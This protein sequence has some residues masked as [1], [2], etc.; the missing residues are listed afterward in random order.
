MNRRFRFFL[1]LAFASCP[2]VVAQ[3]VTTQRTSEHAGFSGKKTTWN[4]FDRYDFACAGRPCLVVTPRRVAPGTPWIW[5]A[6]FFGHRPEVDIALLSKGFHLAFVD[7]IGMFGSPKAVAHRNAFYAFL[8]SEHGFAKKVVLEGMSRGGLDIYN[9]A[10]ANPEKV[11]CIYADAPVCDFKSW[12]GGKGRGKGSPECW[13]QVL[14]AY[15]FSEEQAMAFKGN[16]I[17]NL[18]PL[19]KANVPLLHVSGDADDIVPIEENTRIVERRYKELGGNI[20]VIVKAGIGHK[21]G[22][23]DPAPI[24]DFILKNTIGQ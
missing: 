18:A 20:V 2:V 15:G 7:T 6:R 12:P 22:L 21:H 3:T 11:A 19:A 24:V 16:P 8:T 1:A 10:A 5:R 9:W 14:K 13:Q 17:D 23:D 4:G